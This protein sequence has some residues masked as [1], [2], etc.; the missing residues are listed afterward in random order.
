VSFVASRS[1]LSINVKLQRNIKVICRGER[2]LRAPSES[3]PFSLWLLRK[4][5]K[6]PSVYMNIDH[7]FSNWICSCMYRLCIVML[8]ESVSLFMFLYTSAEMPLTANSLKFSRPLHILEEA[9]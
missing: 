6:C 8:P 5:P 1:G 7:D 3:S 2:H 9:I 4:T